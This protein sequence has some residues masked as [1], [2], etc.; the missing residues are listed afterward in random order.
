VTDALDAILG[1][2][3]RSSFASEIFGRAPLHL[4]RRFTDA[5]LFGWEQL[6][7]ILN[8]GSTITKNFKMLKDGKEEPVYDHLTALRDMRL[9][10][11]ALFENVDRYDAV[12]GSFISDLSK[13]LRCPA[14]FNMYLSSPG[15]QGRQVHFDTHDVFIIQVEGEK[16]WTVYDRTDENSIYA[17]KFH[18][19]PDPN[20][21]TSKEFILAKG[22]VL[23]LPRGFWHDV[24][25]TNQVSL[26]LTLGIFV[27]NGI[28][29]LLWLV[30]ECTEDVVARRNMPLRAFC[31]SDEEYTT[32]QRSFFGE[33]LNTFGQ[34]AQS[35][36]L[37]IS[38]EE[39]LCA[40]LP[41]RTP[42]NFPYSVGRED[43]LPG[44][45][46]PL[47]SR[48]HYVSHSLRDLGIGAGVEAILVFSKRLLRFP[49]EQHELLNAAL[50]GEACTITSLA[51]RYR[52]LNQRDVRNTVRVLL[53]EGLMA[54]DPDV[55]LRRQ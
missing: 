37:S 19:A 11:S 13:S 40:A 26:H 14:R 39:F 2:F 34:R 32:K 49:A 30:D 9:G 50:S 28:D 47:R 25:P 16:K 46:T 45:D 21:T 44:D 55:Q 54:T 27:P 35:K 1:S 8:S 31:S 36:S 10:H 24:M 22:D 3:P 15:Q 33:V 17:R 6:N 51:N 5:P 52:S 53:G 7:S 23:Y 20:L 43:L 42:F 48:V 12:L 18:D 41:N 29:F 4:E 38:Y